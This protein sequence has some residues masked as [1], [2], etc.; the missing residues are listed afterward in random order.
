V[1]VLEVWRNSAYIEPQYSIHGES[2]RTVFEKICHSIES[3]V[4]QSGSARSQKISAQDS[5]TPNNNDPRKKI[6]SAV[7]MAIERREMIPTNTF[8]FTFRPLR[9]CAPSHYRI[10][11]WV[12]QV[13]RAQHPHD[14]KWCS[15]QELPAN[16]I[17]TSDDRTCNNT[18][19]KQFHHT[20]SRWVSEP[21][22][23]S[24][25]LRPR[26]QMAQPH[27][28][29]CQHIFYGSGRNKVNIGFDK[30]HD[31][32]EVPGFRAGLC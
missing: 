8:S 18:G 19:Y 30:Y 12:E 29:H 5:K 21:W 10:K 13:N 26:V 32:D 7:H 6:V 1:H 14:I 25:T 15:Q 2:E 9:C 23:D 11:H 3:R 27:I 16:A 24:D 28:S 4:S 17:N 22:T 31:S 20:R